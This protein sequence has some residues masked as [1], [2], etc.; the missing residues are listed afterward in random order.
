[1]FIHSFN[2]SICRSCPFLPMHHPLTL[3]LSGAPSA[4]LSNLH[5]KVFQGLGAT[6]RSGGL[7]PLSSMKYQ[8]QIMSQGSCHSRGTGIPLHCNQERL[9]RGVHG[10]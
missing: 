9:I 3:P 7:K 6:P 1:M 5:L 8:L 2:I 10:A 4:A